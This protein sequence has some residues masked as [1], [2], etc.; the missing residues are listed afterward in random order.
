MNARYDEGSLRYCC[1]TGI[2][3]NVYHANGLQ[4][5][6]Y[7]ATSF[8]VGPKVRGMGTEVPRKFEFFFYQRG[9][10]A[11]YASAGTV[12]AEMTVRLSVCLSDVSV[13]HILVL[14][15]N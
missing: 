8:R 3:L 12:I 15:Q 14:Y 6:N 5:R 13:H 11:S 9:S 4:T 7:F 2:L 10:I 1:V